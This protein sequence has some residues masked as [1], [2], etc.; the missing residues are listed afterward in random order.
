MG[1]FPV[2]GEDH[3]MTKNGRLLIRKVCWAPPG[4]GSLFT[5][6]LRQQL[7]R[8]Q[9]AGAAVAELHRQ[10][11]GEQEAQQRVLPMAHT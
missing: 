10:G 1:T 4:G 7:L 2:W 11:V 9:Q 3:K 6:E 5:V 8:R